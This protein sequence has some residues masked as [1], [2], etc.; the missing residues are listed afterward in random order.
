MQN[1]ESA[2]RKKVFLVTALFL[3]ILN[4]AFFKYFYFIIDSAGILAG[5]ILRAKEFLPYLSK[6]LPVDSEM[7]RMGLIFIGTGLI[8]KAVIADSM[9]EVVNPVFANPSAASAPEILMAYYTFEFS[10][11]LSV[12]SDGRKQGIFFQSVFKHSDDHD[13]GR[14]VAWC[15]LELCSLGICNRCFTCH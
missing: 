11:R 12:F 3:N 8:K 4:L 5:P 6:P 13:V 1:T 9:A 10:S 7:I 15:H 14:S 2:K